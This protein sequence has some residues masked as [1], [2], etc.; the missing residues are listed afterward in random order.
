ML[1]QQPSAKLR[2]TITAL[3]TQDERIADEFRAIERGPISSGKIV[4]IE[5]DVPVGMKVELG[6]FAEA[7]STRIWD[8]VGR[9]N[10]RNFEDARAFVH[11]LNLKSF[12]DWQI[13]RKSGTKPSDIPTNPNIAYAKAGWPGWGDWLGTGAVSNRLRQFRSFK[14]LGLSFAVST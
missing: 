8:S 4:E 2:R 6:D 14:E 10:W 1:K 5:G 12:A 9:A 7:I 13:Y 3:S 11:S